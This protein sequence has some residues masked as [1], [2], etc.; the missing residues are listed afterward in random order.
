M[1]G[2]PG[3]A[4]RL[5]SAV[6][7]DDEEE[8]AAVL[9]ANRAFYDAFEAHDMDRMSD[10]WEHRDE[11]TCTH[12]GW[13]VLRG[14]GPVAGSWYALFTNGQHLQFIVTAEQVVLAGDVA[15]V[16]CDENLLG[17][18]RGADGT[19]AAL[20]VFRRRDGRWRLVAHHG[21]AVHQR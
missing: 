2:Q 14:W 20:N 13:G 8:L 3:P 4:R 15:W 11:V 12:P 16:T 9:E 19:V 6:V 10:A 5:Q 7:V 18:G 17:D 1:S 21:S